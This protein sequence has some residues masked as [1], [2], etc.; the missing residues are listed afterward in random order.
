[1]R[2][3][4]ALILIFA[5]GF[6]LPMAFADIVTDDSLM[7]LCTNPNGQNQLSTLTF[8]SLTE[9]F[10]HSIVTVSGIEAVGCH[11]MAQ[12]PSVLPS[13]EWYMLYRDSEPT[14]IHLITIN[15]TTGVG[16]DIGQ[17]DDSMQTMAFNSTGHLFTYTNQQAD[18]T[19]KLHIIDKTDASTIETCDIGH[20]AHNTL[21]YDYTNDIMYLLV[22][23]NP[24]EV[25]EI[26][27]TS[28]A[29]CGAVSGTALGT[30][31]SNPTGGGWNEIIAMVWNTVSETFYFSAQNEELVLGEYDPVT[32]IATDLAFL[33]ELVESYQGMGFTLGFASSDEV[34]PVISAT[35]SEPIS[36][37]QDSSFDAFEFVQCIDDVDGTIVPNGDFWYVGDLVDTSTRGSQTVDYTCT[38]D[39]DNNT[40][41]TIQYIVKKKSSSGGGSSSTSGGTSS[42]SSIPQLSDIPVLTFLDRDP[43]MI[44]PPTERRSISDLFASLFSD[45]LN[46]TENIPQAQSVFNSGQSSGS[47]A[48]DRSSPVADFFRNLFSSWFG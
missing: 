7:Y 39:A 36:I 18:E 3:L 33:E 4:I 17:L 47:P 6:S 12:D 35:V 28:L 43:R 15:L 27:D 45:R 11:G 16:T 23:D 8:P 14:D 44:E 1:M 48:S 42:Q 20:D 13:E 34:A 2:Y 25:F 21:G 5:V 10:T 31:E 9:T 26:T 32:G 38:D 46:P 24:S 22:G 40:L 30:Y 29:D 19:N 41:E 37:I